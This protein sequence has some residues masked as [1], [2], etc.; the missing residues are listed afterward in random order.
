MPIASWLVN[1]AHG[2]PRSIPVSRS[3]LDVTFYTELFFVHP[4]QKGLWLEPVQHCSNFQYFLWRR[5]QFVLP[6]SHTQMDLINNSLFHPVRLVIPCSLF[7]LFS[8]LT[9]NAFN[10]FK[11]VLYLWRQI[12]EALMLLVQYVQE[13]NSTNETSLSLLS[14]FSCILFE[15]KSEQ[16]IYLISFL[17]KSSL[18]NVFFTWA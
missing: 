18:R 7:D 17:L 10:W 5:K 14:C 2:D 12:A 16:F 15:N 6:F 3:R 9:G 4:H 1:C 8:G 11:I 13:N